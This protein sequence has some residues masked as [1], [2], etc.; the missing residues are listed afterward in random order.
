MQ[1]DE[2]PEERKERLRKQ[3]NET[4]T[5]PCS[6]SFK[7]IVPTDGDGEEQLRAIFSASSNFSSRPSRNGRYTAHTITKLVHKADEVFEH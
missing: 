7:F 3:L 6:F 4:H 5:W 1:Q 2:T